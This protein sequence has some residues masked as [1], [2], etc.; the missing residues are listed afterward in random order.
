LCLQCTTKDCIRGGDG[1][2]GCEL[3]LFQPRKSSNLDCTFCLDCIHAC[4]H[5]NVGILAVIPGTEL[6]PDRHRSGIGRW[7]RR[8]D[9]AALVLVLVF[10]AFANA[11]GMVA[12]V[13]NAQELLTGDLGL[14]SPWPVLTVGLLG[15]LLVLPVLCVGSA[16]TLSRWWSDDR[17]PWL[18]VALRFTYALVPMGAAC[19]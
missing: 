18:A 12:P 13:V 10:G 19:G 11:A 17:G 7:T 5:A 15:A 4:P 8:T 6:V 14:A 3:N 1:I 2:P 9:L 16:T